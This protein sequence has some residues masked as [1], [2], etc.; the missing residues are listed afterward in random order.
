MKSKK[1]FNADSK[2]EKIRLIETSGKPLA[3]AANLRYYAS[4][5]ETTIAKISPAY[6][7]GIRHKYCHTIESYAK[8]NNYSGGLKNCLPD[9]KG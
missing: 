9:G 1:R 8:V 3:Q 5:Q 4:K 2:R 6:L 7:P